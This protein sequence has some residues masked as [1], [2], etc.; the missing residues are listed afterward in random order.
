MCRR[1]KPAQ[2]SRI[3]SLPSTPPPQFARLRWDANR[4]PRCVLGC[5]VAVPRCGTR[6][7]ALEDCAL[8]EKQT[9]CDGI[10]MCRRLKPA[11]ES[12]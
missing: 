5:P 1:L 8:K 6:L 10:V 2:E 11:R 9:R 7:A 3:T 4:G 12:N